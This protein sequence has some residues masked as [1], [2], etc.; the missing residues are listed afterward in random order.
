MRIKNNLNPILIAIGISVIII[1][2]IWILIAILSSPTKAVVGEEVVTVEKIEYSS[3]GNSREEDIEEL[4][5]TTQTLFQNITKATEG[6]FNKTAYAIEG[7]DFSVL[8]KDVKNKFR[9]VGEFEYPKNKS[10]AYQ[11]V[12]ALAANIE[13]INED[14]S[15]VPGAEQGVFLDSEAGVAAVPITIF[16]GINNGFFLEWVW[17]DDEWLFNPY[18][19]IQSSILA[20]NLVEA[21][22]TQNAEEK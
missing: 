9:F 20:A 6:D 21:E 19:T 3:S 7:G 1:L 17:V 4:I 11:S 8:P 18:P 13:P 12:L 15:I 14:F 10:I 2:G 16:T 22:P 5:S